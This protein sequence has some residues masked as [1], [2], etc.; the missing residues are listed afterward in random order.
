[1]R[2]VRRAGDGEEGPRRRHVDRVAH[3]VGH[4]SLRREGHVQHGRELLL[5]RALRVHLQRIA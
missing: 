3:R 2:Q 1:M 4:P 5:P